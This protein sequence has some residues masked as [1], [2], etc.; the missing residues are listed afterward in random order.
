M[1]QDRVND[2]VVKLANVNGT[3][4]AS[5]NSLLMKAIFRMGVPVSGKNFFPSNIQGLPTWYEIRVSEAG[6]LSRSGRV[7]VMVAMNSQTYLQDLHEVSPG[8]TL[9]YDSTWPRDRMLQRP[10][11]TIIGVPLARMCNEHFKSAR[12]RVLMKNMAYVG[13]LVALLDLDREVVTGLIREVFARKPSAIDANLEAVELGFSYAKEHFECP[14]P[15]R[16]ERRD[17]TSGKIMIDG[18]TATALSSASVP[19]AR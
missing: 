12:T 11:I 18:N 3:G 19:V 5:A 14:L 13:A 8:G 4:S 15:T 2:F 1:S 17:L 10:D 16:V 6:H 9:L 7:D